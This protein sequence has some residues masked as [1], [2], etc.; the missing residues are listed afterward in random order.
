[1]VLERLYAVVESRKSTNP[2]SSYT[3]QLFAEG[4]AKILQKFGEEAIETL[5]AAAVEDAGAVAA[6][7]A[8]LLYHLMVLWVAKGVRP[9]D[10]WEIL[11][12]REG[13]S[14]LDEKASRP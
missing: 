1:M 11:A 6:E 2:K 14:G 9:N 8:D 3:A 10:V 13:L 4:N 7:S 5:V 12:A